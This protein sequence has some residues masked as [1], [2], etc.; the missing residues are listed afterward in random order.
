MNG[1]A[2]RHPATHRAHAMP[3]LRLHASAGRMFSAALLL[4]LCSL[5]LICLL[6]APAAWMPGRVAVALEAGKEMTLDGAALGLPPAD[7]SR[8]RLRRDAAG[9]WWIA[10]AG[11][12]GPLLVRYG[13]TRRR[14]GSA[15][16]SQ[17]QRF[18]LGA[19]RFSVE[20]VDP[21]GVAFSRGEAQW[22][23]QWHYD[24]A[25]LRRGGLPQPDCPDTRLAARA[26]GAWNRL[27]PSMLGIP[28]PLVFGGNLDCG[29]R[30]A[31]AGV[32]APAATLKGSAEGLLLSSGQGAQ[33]VPLLLHT[34][35]A[36]DGVLLAERELALAGANAV[37]VGRGA[38]LLE[39]NG[40]LLHLQPLSHVALYREA[41][42]RLPKG[43]SWS[44]TRRDH[45]RLPPAA[46]LPL[47]AALGLALAAGLALMLSGAA[48]RLGRARTCGAVVALL[49]AGVGVT[50]L[51]LQ[52]SGAPAGAGLVLLTAW[53]ALW[54]AWLAAGRSPAAWAGILLL[55]LGLL[56]QLDMGLGAPDSSWLRHVGKTSALLAI[57]AGACGLLAALRPARATLALPQARVELALL[58]LTGVALLLLVLQVAFGDETGVFDL[59]PVEFAKLAL[60][61]LSAHCLALAAGA[62][63]APGGALLRVLRLGAPALLFLVL[64]AVALV[65]VD[66]YSPLILLTV[67]GGAMA[68]AF[69]LASH[70]Y[71]LAAA[72]M[73]AFIGAVAGVALLRAAGPGEFARWNFYADRFMVWLDPGSHPHTGQQLLLGAQAIAGGGW[74]GAD[75]V[76]GLAALGQDAGALLRI[77]AVQDDFAPSFFLNRHGLVAALVLWLLQALFLAGL[78][79]TAL[80]CWLAASQARDFRLAWLG[81]FRCFLL[82]G[83]AAFV[84]GHFLLSWGTNLAIFP[85]MG[86]P[87]SFL[88]AGGSHLLFFIC[89]LL[90]VCVASENAA[91]AQH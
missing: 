66:D 15:L 89:P 38:L 83:G 39:R 20:H 10:D 58:L 25:S 72:C 41:Q 47:A 51:Y 44:W 35:A 53:A 21:D 82:C 62:Q 56:A 23:T 33:A 4:L 3:A 79:R 24:G 9:A 85:V 60:A 13:D 5:Q 31:I 46:A 6:R 18:Q 69:A 87:M 50:L 48:R 28:R 68:L 84:C 37:Q 74:F 71:W 90:A 61:A 30:I 65:Q 55:A 52:K 73:A 76:F 12:S 8:I 27:L 17:G 36:Q 16:L 77:P 86:Q 54:C 14:A 34:G 80:G 40:D 32:P 81:R 45:W 42:L 70:R 29:N 11:V 67:W 22:H 75:H 57:G 49:L 2:L 26:V 1:A 7:G 43:V 64:L 19:S 88:S 91:R 63:P 59:Q 78:L